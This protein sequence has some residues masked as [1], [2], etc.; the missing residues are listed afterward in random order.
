MPAA[1]GL[2]YRRHF[3]RTKTD[4][5]DMADAGNDNEV[6][7]EDRQ[8]RLCISLTLN[9]MVMR[10]RPPERLREVY[11]INWCTLATKV[12]SVVGTMVGRMNN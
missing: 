4:V 6:A 5:G 7:G 8:N 12:A 9:L 2:G 11:A 1:A 3:R 10:N